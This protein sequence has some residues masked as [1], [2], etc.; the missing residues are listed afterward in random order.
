MS[1]QQTSGAGN[2]VDGVLRVV[3]LREAAPQPQQY[4][5]KPA[6]FEPGEEGGSCCILR[7]M[8]PP[9]LAGIALLSNARLIE[10][11]KRVGSRPADEY[12]GTG[13]RPPPSSACFTGGAACRCGVHRAL[14]IDSKLSDDPSENIRGPSWA[15]LRGVL[16]SRGSWRTSGAMLPGCAA[17]RR[18]SRCR[19]AHT[20]R[21]LGVS[22][23]APALH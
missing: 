23:R 20:L 16:Q 15:S 21:T 18:S 17:T 12:M 14:C 10:V 6:V 1:W 5:S 9:R 11:Y 7:L 4:N 8:R 2:G 19:C 13:A 3:D 22:P